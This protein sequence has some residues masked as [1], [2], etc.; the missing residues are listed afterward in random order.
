MVSGKAMDVEKQM[1]QLAFRIQEIADE[2]FYHHQLFSYHC[3]LY[4]LNVTD[5][6]LKKITLS[7]VEKC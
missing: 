4:G 6:A 1:N 3:S 7:L 5:A 2:H